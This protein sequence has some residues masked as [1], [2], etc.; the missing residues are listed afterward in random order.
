MHRHYVEMAYK[1]S[2][3]VWENGMQ[4]SQAGGGF[5]LRYESRARMRLPRRPPD[6]LQTASFAPIKFSQ[7][8]DVIM[9][10][11]ITT[12]GFDG[13]VPVRLNMRNQRSLRD[14]SALVC[15]RL[16]VERLEVEKRISTAAG[17]PQIYFWWSNG[18]SSTDEWHRLVAIQFLQ[19]RTWAERC[20]SIPQ[21]E[22]LMAQ[23]SGDETS[24][25]SKRAAGTQLAAS[26]RCPVD[27][28]ILYDPHRL[29]SM[30]GLSTVFSG[31]CDSLPDKNRF[32]EV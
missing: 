4:V 14:T 6:G 8:K 10:T 16:G 30:S 15:T 1:V 26:I 20:Q 7:T 11:R 17:N 32:A 13:F 27:L 5:L 18:G 3:L 28:S 12:H 23:K 21:N 24:T 19:P 9:S 29:W 25:W 2:V 22:N 31:F